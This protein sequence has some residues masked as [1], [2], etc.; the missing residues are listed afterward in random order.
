MGYAVKKDK[1]G[2]RSIEGTAVEGDEYYSE[3][4]P[5]LEPSAA[6]LKIMSV[7]QEAWNRLIKTDFS[8]Y[9]DVVQVLKNQKEFTDYR[10]VV[11][12][13]FL[14]PTEDSVFPQEPVA[15]WS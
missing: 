5:N 12:K 14:N 8:Q 13:I 3:T 2:W 9:G 6:E 10:F 15:D 11:R 4:Q 7:K 1:T